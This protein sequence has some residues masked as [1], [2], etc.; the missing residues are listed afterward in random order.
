MWIVKG[1][2]FGVMGAVGMM[3]SIPQAEA[4]SNLSTWWVSFGLP[5]F[6]ALRSPAVDTWVLAGCIAAIPVVVYYE[7]IRDW[8]WPSRPKGTSRERVLEMMTGVYEYVQ[9]YQEMKAGRIEPLPPKEHSQSM[10]QAGRAAL[11]KRKLADLGLCPPGKEDPFGW[12]CYLELIIPLVEQDGVD[13]ALKQ[14]EGWNEAHRQRD[15]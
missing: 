3:V 8:W 10:I 7:R 14:T 9:F 5:P 11:W 12:Q 1:I 6:E 2:L 13:A 15:V 4:I